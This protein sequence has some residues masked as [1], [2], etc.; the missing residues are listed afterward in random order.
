MSEEIKELRERVVDGGSM[1]PMGQRIIEAVESGN[2]KVS[3]KFH[4]INSF[5]TVE[6]IIQE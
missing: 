6:F 3:R 2:K 5:T 1:K 4:I